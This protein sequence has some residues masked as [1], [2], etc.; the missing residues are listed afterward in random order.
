MGAIELVEKFAGTDY[1]V[2]IGGAYVTIYGIFA[3]YLVLSVAIFLALLFPAI[4]MFKDFKT[5]LGAIAGV[6]A[7]VLL[8][9]VC[10]WLSV[11]EPFTILTAEGPQVTSAETMR[12][13]E[14]CIYMLYFML[15]AA[16]LSV[17]IAPL[18]SYLKK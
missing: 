6:G 9:M 5:A 17:M 10:Y 11:A 8:F 16:I 4:Q 3:L 14:A 15:A 2:G 13:V 12:A 1:A 7:L 18:V